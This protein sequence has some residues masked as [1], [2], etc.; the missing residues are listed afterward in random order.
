MFTWNNMPVPA[1]T[2]L[3]MELGENLTQNRNL[4]DLTTLRFIESE[5]L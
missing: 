5:K 3:V 1:F 4:R 2:Q